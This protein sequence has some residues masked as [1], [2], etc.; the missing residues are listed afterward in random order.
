MSG[1]KMI[2]QEVMQRYLWS[3]ITSGYRMLNQQCCVEI[4]L[5]GLKIYIAFYPPP[6]TYY[7][8][9][10][11]GTYFLLETKTKTSNCQLLNYLLR[12]K[13]HS[14]FRIR[15]HLK[16]CQYFK[17]KVWFYVDFQPE[18]KTLTWLKEL[19]KNCAS[20]FS[21]TVLMLKTSD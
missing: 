3:Q 17:L 20:L 2:G 11:K 6:Q 15:E 14:F 12:I 5:F 16:Y 13:S 19:K 18:L 1:V 8:T 9:F 10:Q 7:Q 4:H 21:L